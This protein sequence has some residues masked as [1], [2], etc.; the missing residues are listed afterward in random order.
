MI[1]NKYLVIER[2]G[3]VIPRRTKYGFEEL[4][5]MGDRKLYDVAAREKVANSLY[6]YARSHGR[7]YKI[8]VNH[9]CVEVKYLGPLEPQPTS[10]TV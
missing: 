1:S 9:D 4:V 7:R 3:V 5:K 2:N 6:S 10:E 8:S